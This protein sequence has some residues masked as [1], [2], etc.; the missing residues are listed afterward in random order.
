[1]S[2][3][4]SSLL[5]TDEQQI[6]DTDHPL[7]FLAHWP[8]DSF[9]K[10]QIWLRLDMRKLSRAL[11]GLESSNGGESPPFV[12]AGEGEGGR[13]HAAAKGREAEQLR[14]PLV[15]ETGA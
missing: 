1:M 4:C 3:L 7:V 14:V 8:E 5:Q 11:D 13:D 10:L 6:K 15:C 12:G 9:P 2:P